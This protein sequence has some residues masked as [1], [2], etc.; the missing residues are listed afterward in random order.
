VTSISI[1]GYWIH[2]S[3]DLAIN[4]PP[5]PGEKVLVYLHGGAFKFDTAHP[6]GPMS[7]IPKG[8]LQHIPSLRRTFNVEY[9][10]TTGPP[11][12][13]SNPFPTALLD[14]LAGYIHLVNMGFAE[15]DI[16]ICG[17]S[18]GSQ[19]ALGLTKYLV[20][21]RVHQ[22]K[23]PSPPGALIL[24]SAWSDMSEC[25]VEN[26]DPQSSLVRMLNYDW[27]GPLNKGSLRHAATSFVGDK[28]GYAEEAATNP[29]ISPASPRILGLVPGSKRS[30]SFKGFPK[31][32]IDVGGH[33]VFLDQV[34]RLRDA[35]VEDMGAEMVRYNEV[36]C[37]VHDYLSFKAHELERTETFKK[38]AD[39]VE[40]RV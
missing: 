25:F 7:V 26:P 8:C 34:V 39:W 28:P 38:I 30:I 9:R 13:P 2:K 35:M 31:T 37:A 10:L 11:L 3:K 1:P 19:L 27:L 29:Y 6:D 20:E 17:D 23:L 21:N 16:I 14:V 36:D 22:S 24:L 18:A 5:S 4:A 12:A 32:F 40:E 15:N 33:E